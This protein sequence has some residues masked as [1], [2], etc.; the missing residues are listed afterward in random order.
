[1]KQA[2]WKEPHGSTRQRRRVRLVMKMFTDLVNLSG[3][4][5]YLALSPNVW[6]SVPLVHTSWPRA[7]YVT[8]KWSFID[9]D[10]GF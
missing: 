1:M 8:V 4:S 10:R 9:T 7:N 5:K 6:T 3:T 2:G